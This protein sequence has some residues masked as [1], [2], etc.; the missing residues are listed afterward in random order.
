MVQLSLHVLHDCSNVSKP[1]ARFYKEGDEANF[2][3]VGKA[4]GQ[5]TVELTDFVVDERANA[6]SFVARHPAPH[7]PL[8]SADKGRRFGNTEYPGLN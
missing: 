5:S 4:E 1:N 3:Q 2:H 7:L 8:S 6:G